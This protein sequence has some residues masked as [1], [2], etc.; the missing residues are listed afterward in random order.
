VTAKDMGNRV[1]ARFRDGKTF[2]GTVASFSPLRDRFTI[3]TPQQRV[4]E[5]RLRDLK[6]VFFVRTFSGRPQHNER[7][8][9]VDTCQPGHKLACEFHDGEILVGTSPDPNIAPHGFFL[10]PADP[11][12]NNERVFV[13]NTSTRRVTPFE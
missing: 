6:A 9:F 4:L 13:V 5:V 10:V 1:V 3:M 12:S 8:T 2:K 7:K 11:T